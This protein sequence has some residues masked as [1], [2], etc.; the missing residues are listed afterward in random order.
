MQGK[1]RLSRGNKL[2]CHCHEGMPWHLTPRL[3]SS[4]LRLE[5][6]C[7]CC[8]VANALQYKQSISYLRITIILLAVRSFV[9]ASLAAQLRADGL[10]MGA[11]LWQGCMAS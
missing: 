1:V 8:H 11:I 10:L 2:Q 6:C 7:A 5:A 3:L 9:A 4:P